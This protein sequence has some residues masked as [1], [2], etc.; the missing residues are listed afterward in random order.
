VLEG[1]EEAVITALDMEDAWKKEV[2]V[3]L[4]LV[5]CRDIQ[6]LPT[7]PFSLVMRKEYFDCPQRDSH[8]VHCI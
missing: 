4:Q 6:R 3:L 2:G 1:E 8:A 5:Y 7:T